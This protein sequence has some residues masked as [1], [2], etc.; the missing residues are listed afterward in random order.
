MATMVFPVPVA[1]TSKMRF[2]PRAMAARM[3]VSERQAE[4]V[5]VTARLLHSVVGVDAVTLGLHHADGEVR[6]VLQHV[7]G[8]KRV[9]VHPLS[10]PSLVAF[11]TRFSDKRS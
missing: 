10:S 4:L 2:C 3:R 6:R 8:D 9:A 5:R 11:D 1:S 7:V